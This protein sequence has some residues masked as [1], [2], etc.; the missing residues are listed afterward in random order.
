M[1][2][3]DATR[4]TRPSLACPEC[5]VPLIPAHGR[6]RIDRDD[7]EVPHADACR[8]RWCGWWWMDGEPPVTCTCG[9]VVRVIA[10]DGHAYASTVTP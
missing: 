6:G 8:C 1:T 3:P 2:A 5:S 10:E 9:A 7:N 4:D